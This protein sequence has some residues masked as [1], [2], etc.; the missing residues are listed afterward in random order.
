[1]KTLDHGGDSPAA[2]TIA[3]VFSSTEESTGSVVDQETETDI[4]SDDADSGT[5]ETDQDTDS[6][7]L[8]EVE[9]SAEAQS[10]EPTVDSL[11]KEYGLDPSNP[12]HRKAI[13]KMLKD[14]KATMAMDKRIKDKD[15]HISNLKE[16]ISQGDFLAK[17]ENELFKGKGGQPQQRPIQG[18]QRP[19][20]QDS[21]APSR[22]L[23]DGFDHWKN[24]ADA[25]EEYAAA[26]EAGDKRKASEVRAAFNN[27]WFMDSAEPFVR[28]LITSAI[29]E[30][31]GPVL[32]RDNSARQQQ[33]EEDARFE[34]LDAIRA[35][36]PD[37]KKLLDEMFKHDGGTINV[38]GQPTPSNA[39]WK[40]F[41]EYPEVMD[42]TVQRRT[43]Q[44]TAR[45]TWARRYL[46]LSKLYMNQKRQ[47]TLATEQGEK[48][49][50]TAQQS[51]V[52]QVKK[53]KVR[54]SITGGTSK[55]K[56]RSLS[57]DDKFWSGVSASGGTHGISADTLFT[58]K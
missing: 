25:E 22:Q 23:N 48:I 38:N 33:M 10:G 26:W 18:Q 9:E 54:Q 37:M 5:E 35:G 53:E 1:M 58:R 40:L 55:G 30:R 13:D 8:D 52:E 2:V 49:F 17:F 24:A 19:V 39:I 57:A 21:P 11:A 4:E 42:I 3:D 20:A 51:A 16:K 41:N 47:S 6:Q 44:E 7:S 15:N 12:A 32:Q 27:R 43:P 28:D 36:D 46:A 29:E 31:L 34:A 50:K 45:A 14:A 56:A